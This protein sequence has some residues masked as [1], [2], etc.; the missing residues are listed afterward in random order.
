MPVVPGPARTGLVAACGIVGAGLAVVMVGLLHVVAAGRVDPVRRTIS[1]YA[2]GEHR[3]MFDTGVIGLAA[4]SA[5]VL[6]ALVR[7]GVLRWPS[8]GAVLLAVWAV[9]LVVVVAFEKTNWAVGPSAGGYIHRYASLVAFV[10]LPVAALAAGRRWRGHPDWGRFAA[11]SR[12]L[13]A[14]ALLWL[15]A[16]LLGVVLRP[17]T[18]V[19]WWQF[20]PL[21]LV[22]R[23]LALTEV[24]SVVLL[25]V[26]TRRVTAL[27][28]AA[29]HVAS[30]Q[31][32]AR[33]AG[34]LGSCRRY[35]TFD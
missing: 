7:A 1:E 21:G 2:L 10:S 31:V 32:E 13:G 5:L 30:G 29:D 12:W 6:V 34:S 28:R 11:W 22:E 14:L 15:G 3:W 33:A 19:P 23:A 18:G 27:P 8:A 9:A 20:L 26:W 35:Q 17:F 4:G 24:A 25:G 16:I